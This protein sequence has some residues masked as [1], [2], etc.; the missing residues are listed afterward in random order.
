MADITSVVQGM[1]DAGE[2]EE[3]IREVVRLYKE[4]EAGKA[5]GLTVD[6]TMGLDDMGSELDDGSSE[7]VSWFD[8]TWFGRGIA[9]ATT[10]GEATDLMSEDFSNVSVEAI[11]EFMRAKEE[12]A[13]THVPSERMEKFQ[14]KYKEEGS[15]WSAFFRG[16]KDQPGLLPELFVQS[17]GTQIGTAIDSPGASLAAIGTGAGVGAIGGIPG[18]I[19]GAMGGLATSMEAALT[20]GELIET[21]LKKEGKEFSDVNIKELLEG[22]KGNSIRNKALGRGLA[23]GAIE[24]LTGG[25]AGKAALAT[26]GAVQAARGG[27]V[28]R[29][30][31]ATAAAA[32]VG[33]E[34]IGGG[35][36]EVAGRLAAGQE[37]DPAEIGFE[38]I[39]GTVTAPVNVGG[40]LLSAKEAK[41][42]INDMKNPV[43]YTQ[44]KDFVDTADD[45][46][47]ARAKL[48]IDGDDFTGIG[49][50]AEKKT[51]D[52]HRK[53][54]IDDKITDE[55]DIKDLLSLSY[56]RDNAKADLKKEGVNKVPNAEKK[57]ADIDAKIDAII[58][59][60]EGA[61]DIADTQEAA[62]VRK[63]RR[64]ASVAETIAFAETQGKRIGKETIVVDNDQAAQEAADKLGY[65][66]NVKGSDGFI[67]GN[68]IIINKDVAGRSGAISVGSHEVL[69]GVLAKHMQSLSP[70]GRIKLGKSFMS[71]LTK[72]QDAAVR[73]RLKDDYKLEG[74]NIFS[75]EEIFTAFSDAI[76]KNEITFNE[77]VFSKIKNLIQ[78][79]LRRF[80]IKKDFTDG[81]QAYNFL[82]DYSKSIKNNKLSSRA[83]ALAG[84]GTAVTEGRF[85]RSGA[86]TA[87]NK[88]EQELKSKLQAENKEYTQNEFRR[89]DE[90][91][92]LFDSIIEP[93]GA[94][95]NY[96][97]SLGMS[98]EKTQQ[99]IQKVSDRLMNYN[100]QAERKTGSK[101]AV[102]IGERIMSDTQ[103]AKLDAARDLA[104]EGKKEGKTLR[105]DAAKRTKEGETTFDIEDTGVDTRQ[106]ALE[107]EDLSP[108]AQAKKR[109][110]KA[111]SKQRVES[112]FRNRV[113]FKT[114][115]KI[116][117]EI[118]NVAKKTLIRAYG[119]TL[120]VKDVAA[121]ERAVVAE[122]QKE[123][124]SLTS[125]LFKQIKNWLS[126]G[127][128]QEFVPQSLRKDIYFSNLKEFR[129]DITKL[130]STAD[131][132][133]VERMI[134]EIDRIFTVYK[135]TLTRKGDVEK[136]VDN[137][138]LPPDAIRKYDKDKKVS[139]YD[140]TIPSETQIVAFANQ[141]AKIPAKDKSGNIMRND[142]GDILMVRS[143][144]KGTRKDG[145]TKNIVNGL[146]FDAVMEA[147]QSKE[148][149]DKLKQLD[150]EATSVQEL[151]AATGR[152]VNLK[153]SKNI[154][155]GDISAFAQET[156]NNKKNVYF[157]FG[158]NDRQRIKAVTSLG[159][160]LKATKDDLV[161]TAIFTHM[162]DRVNEGLSFGD[163]INSTY[164]EHVKGTFEG[165][166]SNM[167]AAFFNGNFSKKHLE[168]ILGLAKKITEA[169]INDIAF[170]DAIAGVQ[171]NNSDKNIKKFLRQYSKQIRTAK[172]KYKGKT[173][174]KNEHVL[175]IINDIKPKNKFGLKKVKDGKRI[176]FDGKELFTFQN[177][178]ET[179]EVFKNNNTEEINKAIETNIK[180]SK[181]A[182]DSVIE[183]VKSDKTTETKKAIIKS[184]FADTDAIGRKI[185]KFGIMAINYKGKTVLDHR[186][187]VNKVIKKIF[188]VIDNPTAKNITDLQGFLEQ[189]KINNIPENVDTKLVELGKK[190]EGGMEVM[191]S[192][193]IV[194]LMEGIEVKN[195]SNV[196][197]SR[198]TKSE[199]FV[200]A[201]NFSRSANNPTKGIT[202]LDFDDTLATTKSLVKFTRPDG[203]TGT[204]NAEQYASTYESL[205]DQGYTFDFSEFN[206]VVK[207]KLAPL[208]QKAL[209]LQGKFGPK[210][211]FV[212]TARP[213]AAQ[214]A[215]FDFLKANGLNIPLKNITGLG[216]STAEAKALWVA[217]KVGEGFNDFYFA[218]DALQNVQAVKNML[219]QFDVKSKVQQAK[220]KFSK[221]MN[222]QFNNILEDVTGIEAIKRFSA[223]KARK[224]GASKGKFR[225]FIPPS[226]EDFVGLLYNFM[227]TGRQGDQHRN[228]FEE[229]LVRPLNRAYREI[230][231]AK[232]AIANDYKQLNKQFEDVKDK[233][234]KKTP[235]GDFIFEDA[236]RV[237]L[238]N[239][240]GYEIAGLSE[241]DQANLVE[242]VQSDPNLQAYAENLNV[243]SK[244]EK[245]IDPGQGW[246]GGNIKTDLMDATG[247]VGRAEYFAE[248]NENADIL[249]SEENLNKIEAGYGADFRSA[250]EDILHRTK[251]GVNRPKGQTATTNKFMNYLNGSVGAVMF[252]NTRSAILQQMSIVNYINFADNNIFAAAK[253]F[254]NQKQYWKD[255]AFIFNSDMLKQ[256]RG[257]IGT[258]ING[259]DLAQAVKGSKNPTKIVIGKLLKLGFLPTQIGDNIA[260]ATGGATYYRNRINKYIKDGLSQKEA[261]AKAFTD[262]QDLTQST[263]QSSRPDMTSQQQASW[264]GK[265]V[266][267]FQNITSQYNRII[268]KAALD[269]GKGR[270]SPP[271]TSKAQSNLGNL[272]KILYYGA[273]QN[274]IFYSLQTA[275]FAVM[276]DE[277]EDED[278]ILKKRERVIQGSIDS[279]LRGS[280]IY[281]AVLSTLKNAVVKW[282]QQR[283]KK[284]NKDESAVLMELLNFSPVVGIKARKLVN[285][286]KT[287]NYNENVISEMETFD[288][289]NPQWSAVTNYTEALTNFPANRLYQKSI[290]MRNALD[291][292][293]TMF[294]RIMFFSGYTTWSLGLGDNEA[295]IEAKEKAKINKANTKKRKGRQRT[296]SRSRSR[297][298]DR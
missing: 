276:F 140:K 60:Y 17:L 51:N 253:A 169:Q 99:T 19:A 264:I 144:L 14:K 115:S 162:R 295:I 23:I 236:I 146:V 121:R 9:A 52:A 78:E 20:F 114:G 173:I 179:K 12:E 167:Y 189:T 147:R 35:T 192:P 11:Q 127:L 86:V 161:L 55:K 153:F 289:D 108:A 277:D 202:I 200:K 279:I 221:T 229:A 297:T 228:F 119:K 272:S 206:K 13:R 213:P 157:N 46:D 259:A 182:I 249:F 130:V 41:Y 203:T 260:I 274:V 105:I 209:K 271:Y 18:A 154:A 280:G 245:Y 76:E 84:E 39:T 227:G 171:K 10:T 215:I 232:Q 205:L 256:R 16:V 188:N 190:T 62:D 7:S 239:K 288:A 26:K 275:L 296:R 40:A 3:K 261:E 237:Y 25:I 212:L 129:E 166:E 85:S 184:F 15:T 49:K 106:E 89:S 266:L 81:R 54:Q 181:E 75:S 50:K 180:E 120:N 185:A 69:H 124:N 145:I 61:I 122:I 28:G 48:K 87:V 186:I 152:P 287:I 270:I 252:F 224:R 191:N 254:A 219:D 31:L 32:G 170:N 238:W 262:F 278:Q 111:K 67:V 34:A 255:F 30:G 195:Y 71:V 243:I 269:I 103:F 257:G 143:G 107:T 285:A 148:V 138:E 63:A 163:I 258:D 233:L 298:R 37:M 77:G 66:K 27:K 64:D 198:S 132:V 242:L 6:P 21:E 265:L 222:D 97:K 65:K 134:S 73:K 284:Y 56:L 201:I 45:T 36:G 160:I 234:N 293:Y 291:K 168:N 113:G 230:D 197:Q 112:E 177:S 246:E 283:D 235:D 240:H 83:I 44:F 204:L 88:I 24:G 137:L 57:L 135:E 126:Y 294:Q 131:L 281:G 59:K 247:R 231:T 79:V 125:P 110:D 174:T 244:Q 80:D 218:D 118:L 109:T 187:P 74:D 216:N 210:N 172:F 47:I 151:S 94:V 175:D 98:K 159:E 38:A 104:I 156:I 123:H 43:T 33:V 211:M 29:R 136:A 292:D 82:R 217:D 273:I 4:R 101:E 286:E 1:M 290:N 225:F 196:K 92:K 155:K 139:V 150:V 207:G 251:T 8:Q 142:Q 220:V 178:T 248:F 117:N 91:S 176:T 282:N 268:K 226:H 263:Q 194:E 165:V 223:I 72:E 42:Y 133:Q 158:T 267:N 128:P 241:T 141:P 58:S 183:V 68:S 100:P 149:Q 96:I 214:K 102:T 90:F 199:G 70:E 116:Y 93:G 53:S 193:E 22:P 5:Q 250:L 2:P 208:F 95:N 164:N